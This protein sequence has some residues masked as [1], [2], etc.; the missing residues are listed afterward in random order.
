MPQLLRTNIDT[1]LFDANNKD[2]VLKEN[3]NFSSV[4]LGKRVSDSSVVVIKKLSNPQDYQTGLRF[5]KEAL[6]GI[7]HPNIPSTLDAWKDES[8]Y[9]IIKEFI[10]GITLKELSRTEIL[11]HQKF[12]LKCG[13][14]ILEILSS[15]HEKKIINCD[16]RPDNIIVA[17]SLRGKT[18]FQNPEVYIL[19]FGQSKSPDTF[20]ETHRVPFA[21]IYSPPEQLLNFGKLVDATADIYS[22]AITLY[23]CITGEYAFKH[24]N[25]EML[26]HIQLNIPLQES[27]EI[28]SSLLEILRKASFKQTFN[29]PPAQM[30]IEEIEKLLQESISQRYQS[31]NEFKIAIEDFLSKPVSSS[32]KN[33]FEKIFG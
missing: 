30:S 6:T 4:Y 31:A 19:D 2:L 10:D 23:E 25:P 29:L 9:Y 15:F 24:L 32:K 11:L 7:S 3:G 16:L 5:Q 20:M 22:L 1:Y 21:L 17:N 14:K 18:D 8:G 33:F 13:I 27:R 28:N 26:M 12:F